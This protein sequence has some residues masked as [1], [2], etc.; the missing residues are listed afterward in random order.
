MLSVNNPNGVI[1]TVPPAI[2]TATVTQMVDQTPASPDV[3]NWDDVQGKPAFGTAALRDV[4]PAGDAA[5][6]QAV[7]GSDTRLTGPRE[8]TSLLITDATSTG[9]SVLTATNAGNAR[10]A[11]GITPIGDAV[12]TAGSQL[13]GR[14]ALGLG[15]ISTQNSN[16]VNITGGTIAGITDLAVAD[17]GTG[18]STAGG[19]RTNLGSGATGDSL[20]TSA[21]VLSAL[22]ILGLNGQLAFRNM[23]FNGGCE[24][25][26]L[27]QAASASTSGL[28]FVDGILTSNAATGR[29]TS[30]QSTA[31][32]APGYP[33]SLLSTVTT[34][35][36]PAA[37]D[38]HLHS[39]RI[40]GTDIRKLGY[41]AAGAS[42]VVVQ[43]MVRCSITGT[44]SVAVGNSVGN[45]SYVTTFTVN[46][47]NTWETKTL[48]IP[49]DTAGAWTTT[50]ALGM[51]IHF[52]MAM[53][54]TFQ[55]A[56]LNAWQAGNLVGATGQTQLTSTN[57]ATFQI[58]AI[59]VSAGTIALP[60]EVLPLD[61]V[62]PRA[63]R[64]FES[65][66]VYGV[67]PGTVG[68]VDGQTRIVALDASTLLTL[69]PSFK[70]QKVNVPGGAAL[71]NPATGG[72]GAVRSTN[73]GANVAITG[74][75]GGIGQW[76]FN[77]VNSAAGFTAGQYYEF[78]YIVNARI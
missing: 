61:I 64:Y 5:P 24:C 58:T 41:G 42:S 50:A 16:A 67:A 10:A 65:S 21:S 37:G 68:A 27:Q 35:G 19:A 57:G 18:S 48:V 32:A 39:L 33:F 2:N 31:N 75:G 4:P 26:I 14:N 3:V 28:Y 69:Q 15:T 76:G 17:G 43:F 59:D 34:S 12:V 9:R 13:D 54:T 70:T 25:N 53:G 49:G 1:E 30:Q 46:A 45:R 6:G 60:P 7:L 8:T 44:F 11:I 40:G 29:L 66:Y 56:T 77:Q 36:A 47:A 51:Q 52:G 71:Y 20:F 23:F 55:T 78:Q 63:E 22:G 74:T 38:V 62:I 73:T 72:S